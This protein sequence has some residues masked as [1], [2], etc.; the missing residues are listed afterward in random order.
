M[1]RAPTERDLRII[2]WQLG[3]IPYRV[4]AIALDCRYGYPQLTVN[5]PLLRVGNHPEI[6]PTLFWLTCP[7]L[8]AEVGKLEAAGGVKYYERLIREDAAT[9]AAYAQAHARYRAERLSL[10][11]EEER[12]SMGK[13][14]WNALGTGIGGLR[15]EKQV[16]C[17]HAQLA[18]YLARGENPIGKLVAAELP[19]LECQPDR[20]ICQKAEE[21]K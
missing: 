3:R 17:L 19:R 15:N 7:Y 11:S 16:K 1:D 4:V 8:V 2:S 20:V 5:H 6:F 10:V 21:E 12:M 13:R 9:S 14:A 18:H